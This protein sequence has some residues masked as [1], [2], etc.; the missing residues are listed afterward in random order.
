[1]QYILKLAL[2]YLQYISANILGNKNHYLTAPEEI[3]SEKKSHRIFMGGH[4]L[5]S[6]IITIIIGCKIIPLF[7]DS[8]AKEL[9]ANGTF[10]PVTLLILFI[11]IL[12][13]NG[14]IIEKILLNN[15]A[16]RNY[17]VSAASSRKTL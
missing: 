14:I 9:E 8:Y 3:L 6:I 5:P 17:I 4:L 10:I 11:P 16:Y 12:I 7:S 2:K 1:M 15:N 13:L